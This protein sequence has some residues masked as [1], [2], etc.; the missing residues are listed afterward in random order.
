MKR[1]ETWRV[2]RLLLLP[3][4]LPWAEPLDAGQI[5][6]SI[7]LPAPAPQRRSYRGAQY[8]G[9]L[10]PQKQAAA[11]STKTRSLYDDVVVSAHPLSFI[12]AVDPLPEPPQME[13]YDAQFRPRVL[14]ITVNTD[15]KSVV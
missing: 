7:D 6:G 1:P 4:V 14:P 13:Q 8:R 10:A 15:R 2:L 9:R 12:A 3:L 11:D 5:V